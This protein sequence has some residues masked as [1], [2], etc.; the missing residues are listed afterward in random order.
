MTRALAIMA[1]I[2]A[3]SGAAGVATLVRPSL[4]RRVIRL[5]D[6]EPTTYALRIAGMMLAALGLFLT[7]F[8]A[9][10]ALIEVQP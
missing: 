3:A 2:G 1:G 5:P 7:G 10:G 9:M 8:A 4:A 6:A